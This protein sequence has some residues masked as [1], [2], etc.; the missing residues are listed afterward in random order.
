MSTADPPL[1]LEHQWFYYL[2]TNVY[3][4]VIVAVLTGMSFCVS[5][6]IRDTI[7]Q[8]SCLLLQ[9]FGIKPKNQLIECSTDMLLVTLL[10]LTIVICFVVLTGTALVHSLH[11]RVIEVFR[12]ARNA[13]SVL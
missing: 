1:Q 4:A 13:M 9:T 12:G 2:G 3:L 5:L 6:V 11:L 10:E 7:Y 8:L